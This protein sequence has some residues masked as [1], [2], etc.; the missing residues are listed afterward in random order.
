[1]AAPPPRG[2]LGRLL[3]FLFPA[4]PAKNLAARDLAAEASAA[5]RRALDRAAAT[6]GGYQA[7]APRDNRQRAAGD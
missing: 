3:G 5:H 2:F 6:W 7:A 1:M 4:Q